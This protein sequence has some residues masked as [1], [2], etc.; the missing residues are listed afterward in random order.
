VVQKLLRKARKGT[1]VVYI[2]GNHDENFRAFTGQH[3]GRVKVVQNA[4]HTMADGRRYLVLHGD[5]FDGVVQ[6]AR[7]LAL[8]GDRAY[9]AA[10][11]VNVVLNRCRQRSSARSSG[12][13]N[14]SPASRPRWCMRR[15]S[16]VSMASYAAISTLRRCAP[17][18]AFTTVMTATGSKAARRWWSIRTGGWRLSTGRP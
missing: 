11:A 6:Y 12:R 16:A 3:F 7:W 8:L 4:V 17:S 18:P 14:I 9:E 1:H 2:P 5:E 15:K 13:W 10:M